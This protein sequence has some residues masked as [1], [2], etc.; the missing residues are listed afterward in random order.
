ME[1]PSPEQIMV[2]VASVAA[3]PSIMA[4]S[5]GHRC[6]LRQSPSPSL[7]HFASA[8]TRIVT[9]RSGSRTGSPRFSASTCSMPDA[10]L[11][12]TVYCLSR[13][14]ASPKQ[15]KNWLLAELGSLERAIEHTPRTCGSR[16]TR[17]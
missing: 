8:A 16:K 10:T 2:S 12:H 1:A 15:M 3:A 6:S 13:N 9:I 14:F 7:R 4:A 17:P 5:A 11:P